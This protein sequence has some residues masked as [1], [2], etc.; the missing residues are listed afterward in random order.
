[1]KAKA[2]VARR[3]ATWGPE[4]TPDGARFRLWAPGQRS[5][6]LRLEGRDHPMRG[7]GDGWF[8]TVRAAAPGAAYGFVL[9][10]GLV[11]PDPAARAQVADA[12]GLSRL[13]D[14]GAY[15]WRN[16]WPGRPWHE[17]IISELH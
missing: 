15:R 10:D 11:V 1:M 17:A 8:E 7:V 16:E 2:D 6:R 12:H 13:V 9:D 14:P 4:L 5:V 3:A